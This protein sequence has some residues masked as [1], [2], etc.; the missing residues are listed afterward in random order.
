MEIIF[1]QLSLM[2]IKKK[3]ALSDNNLTAVTL[4]IGHSRETAA[5]NNGIMRDFFFKINKATKAKYLE[6]LKMTSIGKV[7]SLTEFD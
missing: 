6:N 3:I 4:K 7:Q 1:F 5:R 2:K